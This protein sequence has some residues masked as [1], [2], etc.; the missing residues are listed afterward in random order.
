MTILYTQPAEDPS[1][2]PLRQRWQAAMLA[3]SL[4]LRAAPGGYATMAALA[5][6]SGEPP[7]S[8]RG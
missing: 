7:R 1:V 4:G 2:M 3:L 5:V 6:L 8:G